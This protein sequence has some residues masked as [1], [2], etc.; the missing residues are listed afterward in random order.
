MVFLV[1]LTPTP[2]EVDAM[3]MDDDDDCPLAPSQELAGFSA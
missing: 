1:I 3:P 2:S